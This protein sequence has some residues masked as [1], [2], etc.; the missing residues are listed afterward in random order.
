[1]QK[2]VRAICHNKFWEEHIIDSYL[3]SL[4][5][6]AERGQ[7]VAAINLEYTLQWKKKKCTYYSIA[8]DLWWY[9]KVYPFL[10]WKV[11]LEMENPSLCETQLI[12]TSYY[13][14]AEVWKCSL[15]ITKFGGNVVATDEVLLQTTYQPIRLCTSMCPNGS[16]L[17][18][19]K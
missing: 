6:P 1:M 4:V 15:T 8:T 16:T 5:E 10:R 17:M 14:K 11:E 13:W 19:P 9:Y 3:A 12:I 2:S 18:V 7:A